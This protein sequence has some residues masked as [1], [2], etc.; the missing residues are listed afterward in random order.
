MSLQKPNPSFQKLGQ[1]RLQKWETKE[2]TMVCA[3]LIAF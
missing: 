2:L 1:I 3:R